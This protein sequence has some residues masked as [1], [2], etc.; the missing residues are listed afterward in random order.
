[1]TSWVGCGTK[2]CVVFDQNDKDSPRARRM[3]ALVLGIFPRKS[4]EGH[5][6]G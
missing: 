4:G 2:P 3:A 5:P 1:M 6:E